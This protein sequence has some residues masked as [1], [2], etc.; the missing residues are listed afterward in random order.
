MDTCNE[1]KQRSPSVTTRHGET[2]LEGD[3]SKNH[4]DSAES[5]T[6]RSRKIHKGKRE[7][8]G[9]DDPWWHETNVAGSL[10]REDLVVELYDAC[11]GRGVGCGG[12]DVVVGVLLGGLALTAAVRV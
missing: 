12:D 3:H 6:P 1:K 7:R 4:C 8:T 9:D 11:S 5:M 10:A 2:R